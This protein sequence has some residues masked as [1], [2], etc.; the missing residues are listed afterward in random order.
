MPPPLDKRKTASRPVKRKKKKYVKSKIV[1]S[2]HIDGN[3][4]K[5]SKRKKEEKN[6]QILPKNKLATSCHKTDNSKTNY[7]CAKS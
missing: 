6:R 2:C 3:H 7:A 4:C 5:L 1:P